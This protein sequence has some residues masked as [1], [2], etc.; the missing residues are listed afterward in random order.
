MPF[1]F[2]SKTALAC[3]ALNVY[4][5][6]AISFTSTLS[7]STMA[8]YEDV[9]SRGRKSEIFDEILEKGKYDTKLRPPG[10]SGNGSGPTVIQVSL[11]I[12]SIENID[13]VKMQYSVQ[14]TFRQQWIDPRLKY[15]HIQQN[16]KYL[17]LVIADR[18]WMPDI[19]FSNEKEGNLH[20]LM[21]PN[22]FTRI[23]PN[24]TVIQSYRVT[25]LLSCPMNLRFYP[26]DVQACPIQMAS[27]GWTTQNILLEWKESEYP[28]KMAN[29]FN[30][31][32]QER[33]FC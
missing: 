19:F 8:D 11:H 1:P 7:T 10:L 22:L 26:L 6:V 5:C 12:R 18:I 24:G 31:P 23:Y 25:L 20:K 4:A 32:R 14:L 27:Y 33:F 16:I 2:F 30:M 3:F 17:Q 21:T 15:S 13:D 9:N 28:V 29:D